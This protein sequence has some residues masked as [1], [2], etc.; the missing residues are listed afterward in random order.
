MTVIPKRIYKMLQQTP[1]PTESSKTLFG[2]AKTI[3]PV[4]GCFIGTVQRGDKTSRQE[5]FVVTGACQALLGQPAIE[6]LKVVEKV[7][8][9]EAKDFKAEFPKLFKGL[10]K[11][12]GP[13]YVIKLKPD[14]KP[15]ALCTPRRV[16]VPLFSKV[17][18]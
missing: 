17:R 8:E 14:A 5:I 16:P 13:D 6:A 11:L 7:N 15:H 12:D 1:L 10:G 18:E 3:L 4:C 2:L 9:V